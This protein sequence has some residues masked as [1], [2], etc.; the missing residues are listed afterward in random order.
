MSVHEYF[1][2]ASKDWNIRDFLEECN[3][4][5]FD[6]K[7]DCYTKSLETIVKEGGGNRKIKAQRL[8]DNYKKK[9]SIK[10]CEAYIRNAILYV[11]AQVTF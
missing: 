5:P 10:D 6:L 2:C 3:L 11:K 8:L 4:E 9:A 7:T 1:D